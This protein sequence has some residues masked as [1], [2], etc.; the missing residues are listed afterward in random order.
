VA[1]AGPTPVTTE[2]LPAASGGKPPSLLAPLGTI[3]FSLVTGSLLGWI[4][5][6]IRRRG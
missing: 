3:A 4:V 6:E 1:Q 2:L 5:F